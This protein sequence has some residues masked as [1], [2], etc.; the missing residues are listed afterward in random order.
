MTAILEKKEQIQLNGTVRIDGEIVIL[1]NAKLHSDSTSATGYSE[2]TTNHELY[3][4]N[5]ETC[6]QQVAAFKEHVR[7]KEDA[8][9]Q[10]YANEK[11]E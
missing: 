11:R 3:E 1:L 9:W 4:A 6:R 7:Q 5:K 10:E 2:V 8:L